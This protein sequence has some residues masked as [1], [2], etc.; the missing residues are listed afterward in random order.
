MATVNSLKQHL[1]G[2][3]PPEN[4]Q[5]LLRQ[6]AAFEERASFEKWEGQQVYRCNDECLNAAIQPVLQKL[7]LRIVI[8][9]YL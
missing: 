8:P 7:Q 4:I 6:L 1:Q 2:W 9:R 3:D 5:L